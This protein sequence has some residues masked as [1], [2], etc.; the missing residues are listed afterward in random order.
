MKTEDVN[1]TKEVRREFIKRLGEDADIHTSNGVVYIIFNHI[2]NTDQLEIV[3]RAKRILR[4]N[5]KIRD[6]VTYYMSQN[7]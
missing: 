5:P 7:V 6:I 2:L 1:I 4:C 3:E